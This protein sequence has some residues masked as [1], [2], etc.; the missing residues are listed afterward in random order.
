MMG[1]NGKVI[2]T[3]MLQ[4]STQD[5]LELADAIGERFEGLCQLYL[6]VRGRQLSVPVSMRS[7]MLNFIR[8]HERFLRGDH[9]NS[10]QELLSARAVAQWTLD[11]NLQLRNQPSKKLVWKD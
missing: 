8:M 7:D 9:R 3:N 4:Q 5:T 1:G 6:R 11:I 2:H 10:R